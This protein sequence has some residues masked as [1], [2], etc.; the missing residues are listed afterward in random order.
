[1]SERVSAVCDDSLPVGYTVQFLDGDGGIS[2]GCTLASQAASCHVGDPCQI[3]MA[4]DGH[5]EPG[6]CE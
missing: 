4:P 6:R 3:I 2:G 5:I 1:V